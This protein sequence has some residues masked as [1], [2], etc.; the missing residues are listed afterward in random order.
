[1]PINEAEKIR[2]IAKRRKIPLSKLAAS[3][4]MSSQSF[5]GKLNRNSFSREELDTIAALLDCTYKSVFTL[6]DT[7]EEI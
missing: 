1:M 4:A 2:I 7:K 6:N 3:L 5:N